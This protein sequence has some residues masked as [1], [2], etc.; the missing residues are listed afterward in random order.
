MV[1]SFAWLS[2]VFVEEKCFA[3][4]PSQH[5]IACCLF[6]LW[7]SLA[8][9]VAIAMAAAAAALLLSLDLCALTKL[10]KLDRAGMLEQMS[11]ISQ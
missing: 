9:K 3:V 1:Q 2:P 4:L 8:A 11:V 7:N 5:S 6:S 10:S